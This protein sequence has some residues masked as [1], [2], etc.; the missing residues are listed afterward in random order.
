MVVRGEIG[1]GAKIAGSAA[2]D[3]KAQTLFE[4]PHV[5]TL[6]RGD[7]LNVRVDEVRETV[8]V[9]PSF[10]T[11]ERRPRGKRAERGA[12]RCRRLVRAAS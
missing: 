1:V 7:S 4:H 12:D 11:R 8:E 6:D 3:A 10:V 5:E 2:D 9:G